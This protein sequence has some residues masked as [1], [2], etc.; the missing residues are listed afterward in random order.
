MKSIKNF[1]R[2]HPDS[3]DKKLLE[4]YIGAIILIS[5]DDQDWYEYQKTFQPDTMK[6]D[7]EADGVIRSMGY[8]ISGF[9]QDGCSIA[10]VSQWPKEAVPN[11]KWCFVDGQVVPR[12][13]TA[14]ELREQATHKRDYLLEQAAK[15]I[16]SLEDA[17][18]FD[19]A[20]DPEK[21]ALLWPGKNTE[22]C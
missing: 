18:D 16:A 15:I 4:R 1:K 7:Y 9:C 19:M 13:Y 6:V 10:E 5:E 14:D 11:R 22:C 12:I 8:D 21:S 20:T 2:Y 3:V 17:V